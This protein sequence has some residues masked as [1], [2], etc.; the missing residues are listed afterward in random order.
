MMIVV[1]TVT[2][3]VVMT[4]MTVMIVAIVVILAVPVTA[5]GSAAKID[6]NRRTIHRTGLII[7]VVIAGIETQADTHLRLRRRCRRDD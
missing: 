1:T 2:A 3:A 4:V 7:A 5:P 6:A